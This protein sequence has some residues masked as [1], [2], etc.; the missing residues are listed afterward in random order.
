MKKSLYHTD[1]SILRKVYLEKRKNLTQ[2][3]FDTR[4]E[5]ILNLI[6]KEF[7]FKP[8]GYTHIFLPIEEFRE[9]NTRPIIEFLKAQN[10]QVVL[11][12]SKLKTNDMQHFLMDENTKL[13][14]NKW[15][16]IEPESGIEVAERML[17]IVF[18]PLLVF[19]KKGNRIGY[20]KG[21]Y[22]KFLSKCNEQNS[23]LPQG[24]R[25]GHS[26]K[27]ISD[28]R[29]GE[30]NQMGYRPTIKIGLSLSAPLDY[31]ACMSPMDVALDYCVCPTGVY[32]F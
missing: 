26:I 1:K 20:G 17:N 29:L 6:K 32:K 25:L 18:V 11:S 8:K 14:E 31:I 22:D 13:V 3:E 12:K 19:D 16:I 2:Q 23:K 7:V 5:K 30:L 24:K 10:Q 27:S 28:S 21:Y 4:N 15:G 9:V